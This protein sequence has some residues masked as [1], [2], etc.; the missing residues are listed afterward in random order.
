VDVN[1][2]LPYRLQFVLSAPSSIRLGREL[3]TVVLVFVYVYFGENR[4]FPH[5]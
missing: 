4:L 2:L 5:V 1:A 3:T